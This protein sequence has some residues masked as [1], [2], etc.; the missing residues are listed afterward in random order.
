MSVVVTAKNAD[1]GLMPI[2]RELR[3]RCAKYAYGG[4]ALGEGEEFPNRSMGTFDV[5][6]HY[7]GLLGLCFV[8]FVQV[9]V[10]S[11]RKYRESSPDW[12]MA[13]RADRTSHHI[14][15]RIGSLYR[16]R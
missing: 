12:L 8:F 4:F 10:N 7:G 11:P 3:Q 2:S 9:S 15:Q 13:L 5:N 16:D 14:V 1:W 6:D